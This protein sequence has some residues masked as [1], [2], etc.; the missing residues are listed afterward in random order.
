MVDAKGDLILGTADNTV[1]RQAVGTNNHVLYADS[2]QTNGVA[3]AAGSKS[4]LT[5]TGD[6]LYASAA[7]TLARLGIGSSGQVLTVSGGLP[8]WATPSAGTPTFVGCSLYKSADQTSSN[9]TE[10]LVTF[11]SE[12][13]DTDGFHDTSTNTG[14]I[15]IPTGKGGKYRISY[16]AVF[17]YNTTSSRE[18]Y[19]VLNGS[20]SAT[21]KHTNYVYANQVTNYPTYF[22][23]QIILNLSAGDYVQLILAQNSGG[24]LNIKG[25]NYSPGSTIFEAVYLGA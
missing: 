24:N 22:N 11:D 20:T 17:A 3:W 25:D 7:N 23:G 6:V 18:A 1:A 15:T 9:G 12:R 21:A 14:R 16:Q 19:I 2:A 4:T 13:I 5:T 10:T 8:S